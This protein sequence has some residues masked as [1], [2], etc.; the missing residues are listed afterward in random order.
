MVASAVLVASAAV[1]A[2]PAEMAGN[3]GEEKFVKDF[4]NAWNKVMTLDRL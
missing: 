4:V 2:A 1:H 3:D